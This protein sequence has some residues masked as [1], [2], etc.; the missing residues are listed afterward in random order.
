MKKQNRR[1]FLRMAGAGVVGAG[2]AVAF[3]SR[4]VDAVPAKGL[5]KGPVKMGIIAFQ[6]G[7]AAVPGVAGI[8]TAKIWADQV[9][10]A[11][12]ILGRKV[13]LLIEEESYKAKETVEKFK[14]LTMKNK[15]DVIFGTISTGNGLALAK[16]A[17]S[18]KKLFLSWDGTTQKGLNE[19]LFH[20]TY[21]FR[22]V[23]N[24]CEIISAAYITAKVFPN[25]KKVAGL[26]NDYSYGRNAWDAF[27][28]VLSM[29]NPN[30]KFEE[31]IFTKFGETD[32][33]A[34]IGALE[35]KRP[36]LIMTSFW[37]ADAS[38][39]LKQA[40]G[41]D[42]FKKYKG[43]ITSAGGPNYV[44]LKKEFTP[45]GMVMGHGTLFIDYTDS[46]PLLNEFKK[47][48]WEKYKEYP[49][50]V[51]DHAWFSLAA[52]KLAIEK[53]YEFTGKWPTTEE[54]IWALRNINVPSLSGYRGYRKDNKME[55]N[56][57]VGLTTHNNPY[58]F[59][60]INPVYILPSVSVQKPEGYTFD[61]WIEEWSKAAKTQR[62]A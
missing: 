27:K 42:L 3:G 47:V 20:P 9:N 39:F 24:E 1:E 13:E 12:G 57:F 2:A 15:C 18:L 52:Y 54:I 56:F 59:V 4:R 43:A 40:A 58:D 26:N 46:W 25:I 6:S 28:R 32:F 45:E 41:R 37:G 50:H 35:A 7:V 51:C 53:F 44:T 31:G 23:D 14:K 10:N 33:T 62:S 11:G 60:T 38:I 22:S 16:Q 29:Y 34:A 55:C 8:R 49:N 61:Q 17:E 36:D 48:F 5:P 21:T 19:T 30:V